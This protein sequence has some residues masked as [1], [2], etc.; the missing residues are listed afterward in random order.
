MPSIP[1]A[2]DRF[3]RWRAFGFAG[4]VNLNAI[5]PDRMAKEAATIAAS[6]AAWRF[7]P[8]VG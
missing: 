7:D 2:K 5:S 8:V 1:W 4:G 6:N 3:F